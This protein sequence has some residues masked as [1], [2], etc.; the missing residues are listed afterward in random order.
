MAFNHL[1]R[2]SRM[3]SELPRSVLARVLA[4]RA[5]VTGSADHLERARAE[6]AGVVFRPSAWIF[7]EFALELAGAALPEVDTQWLAPVEEVRA[8]WYRLI[9]DLIDRSAAVRILV[10]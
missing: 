3:Q 5:L 10:D 4:L 6:A 8:N 7:T 2:L 9:R 1:E